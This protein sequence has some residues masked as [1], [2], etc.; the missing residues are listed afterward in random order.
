MKITTIIT[1]LLI[2]IG[3]VFS[4]AP[5]VYINFVSHNEPNENLQAPLPF[6]IMVT[7]VLQLASIIDN[8]GASWN[9]QTCDGF[10]KGALDFQG[11]NSNIFKT[12]K[13][14]P[15]NDNLEIDPR[16][17]Q[18]LYPTIADL[19]HTLDSLG[20]SPTTT[21]GGFIY[22][23]TTS[24]LPDWFEYQDTII[25]TTS[26]TMGSGSL[27]LLTIF[28]TTIPIDQ[29]GSLETVVNRYSD[30]TQQKIRKT[31]LLHS[32]ILLTVFKMAFCHKIS[33]MFIQLQ[34]IKETLA[35][36]YFKKCLPFVIQ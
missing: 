7:K 17:K 12:L 33:S 19:Y 22:S 35:Q 4:Q 15:Y 28:I 30:L 25:P 18:T 2:S 36:C 11:A 6:N 26:M 34:L 20:A 8:K 24:T 13:Q 5:K 21:L 14:P 3:S 16:N 9:L 23:S 31:L 29:F 27:I 32:R 10:A 1:G